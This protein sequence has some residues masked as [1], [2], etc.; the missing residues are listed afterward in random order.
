MTGDG[1][2]ESLLHLAGSWMTCHQQLVVSDCCLGRS[3]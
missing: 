2:L 1:S 3:F